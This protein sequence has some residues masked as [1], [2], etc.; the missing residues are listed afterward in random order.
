MENWTGSASSTA[1]R[2]DI[3]NLTNEISLLRKDIQNLMST[4]ASGLASLQ[5]ISTTLVADETANAT[6]VQAILANQV[7]LNGQITALSAQ[8]TAATAGDPDS[9]VATIAASLATVSSGIEANTA[10]INA[11]LPA[12]PAAS[13][14]AA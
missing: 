4:T 12:A 13:T 9:E 5:A 8:L 10:A 6:A 7:A 2:K 11:A 3:A 14:P 1:T